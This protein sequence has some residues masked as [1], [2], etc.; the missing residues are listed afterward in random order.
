[1][2]AAV[3]FC[4]GISACQKMDRPELKE[5]IEDPEPPPYNPLKSLWSFEDNVTDEGENKLTG[6]PVDVIYVE[7][8]KGEA[9]KIEPGGYLLLKAE[10]DTV[11]YPNEFV[12]LPK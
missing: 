2:F 7:G 12:G 3:V 4:L 11:T 1:L 5:I 8:V 6:A 9:L 10:G